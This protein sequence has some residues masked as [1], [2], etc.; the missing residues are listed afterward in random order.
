MLL[1]LT[2]GDKGNIVNRLTK[3]GHPRLAWRRAAGEAREYASVFDVLGDRLLA[4]AVRV[5]VAPQRS[6]QLIILFFAHFA[7]KIQR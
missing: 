3:I 2:F 4:E 6:R 7:D 5:D 1:R